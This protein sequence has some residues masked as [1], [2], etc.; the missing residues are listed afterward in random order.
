MIWFNLSL[1]TASLVIVIT[2]STLLGSVTWSI[3]L[4]NDCFSESDKLTSL[5]IL[6]LACFFLVLKFSF[7][8]SSRSRL[9]LNA[10]CAAN[11]F[12]W[13]LSSASLII[14]LISPSLE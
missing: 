4:R 2:S 3:L 5:L 10:S 9:S 11:K 1:S 6:A 12:C 7:A 14:E 8:F 13:S